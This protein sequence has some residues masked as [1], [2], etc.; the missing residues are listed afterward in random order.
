MSSGALR[1]QLRAAPY[2]YDLVDNFGRRSPRILTP[3][4]ELLEPGQRLMRVFEL[5]EFE[6]DRQLTGQVARARVAFGDTAVTYMVRDAQTMGTRLLVK[7][8]FHYP[9]PR[10]AHPLL[11]AILPLADTVMMRRQ[12]LNLKRFAERGATATPA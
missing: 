11:R 10:F 8:V 5:K 3:G 12:L 4:L 2:S 6:R 7:V 1:L 9:L